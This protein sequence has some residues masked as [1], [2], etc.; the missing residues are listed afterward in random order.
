MKHAYSAGI[1]AYYG[2]DKH[3]RLYLVLCYHPNYWGLSKGR[4]E[5]GETKLQAAERELKEETNLT[6]TV[7]PGFETALFYVFKDPQKELVR[8]EVTYFVGKAFTQDVSLSFEHQDFKWLPLAS[9]LMQLTYE[10]DREVLHKADQ[11]LE[12]LDRS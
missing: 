7:Y 1:V 5:P 6:V 8:K 3:E 9:A 4:V 2:T 10:K 11:F 12:S